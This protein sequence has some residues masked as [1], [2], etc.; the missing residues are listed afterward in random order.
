MRVAILGPGRLGRSLSILLEEAGHELSTWR[1]G[2]PVPDADVLWITVRDDAIEDV[3]R[4]VPSTP[5]LL[6]SS[7]ALSHEILRA[8]DASRRVGSLHPI[9][10]FAG[11]ESGLP[12]LR[13]VFA[14]LSGDP[15]ALE[16]A[17]LLARSMGMR[18]VVVEGSRPL[19]HVACVLAGNFTALL[20]HEAARLLEAC[21][22]SPELAREMLLPLARQALANAARGGVGSLTGPH[23]RADLRTLAAHR[24]ALGSSHPELLE[25]YERL[26]V[27]ASRT[28]A[29]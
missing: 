28:R 6:H 1:R 5:I 19:Y 13:G 24:E 21:G 29:G 14:A 20:L 10:T 23:A 4:I 26:G 18:P 22:P 11:P 16:A 15:E 25:A 7:G 12:D 17:D 2:E 9:Q 3:A 27:L 8:G